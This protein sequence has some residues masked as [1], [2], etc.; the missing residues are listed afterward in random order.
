VIGSVL[1]GI[2]EDIGKEETNCDSKLIEADNGATDPLGGALGL[3]HWYYSGDQ[4]DTKTSNDT[5][6]DEE[7]DGGCCCLEGDTNGEDETRS[8]ETPF[9]TKNVTE[10]S[11]K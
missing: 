8:D 10:G 6:D 5:T 9:A 1:G 4:T 11:G 3:V 7:R 2:V